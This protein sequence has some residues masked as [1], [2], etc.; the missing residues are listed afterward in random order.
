MKTLSRLLGA[1]GLFA[2]ASAAHADFYI[3]AGA[4]STSIDAAIGGLKDDTDFAP[5]VFLGWRPIE[6]VGV[7]AGY[8]DLGS[9]GPIDASA[10]TLAGL[11]SL[12]LGPVGVYAKGGLARTT[13]E[14]AGYSEDN[15]DPFAGLGLTIDLMDKL[16]VYGEYLRF[17]QEDSDVDFDVAGVGLRYAF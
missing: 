10:L 5:A 12:E 14:L 2:L 1:A 4:Y 16:Y 6:L 11:L 9:Y 17:T 15:A 8:Y 7:E 13:V 3:G